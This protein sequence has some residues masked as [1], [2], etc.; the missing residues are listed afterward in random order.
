MRTWIRDPI[1]V[2]AEG[3]AHGLIV[4]DSR[5]AELVGPTGPSSTYDTTF[6]AGKHV[7][8]RTSSIP[9]ITSFRR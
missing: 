6:E 4:E 9:I 1:A 2:L 8:F 3:A 7:S 5:I